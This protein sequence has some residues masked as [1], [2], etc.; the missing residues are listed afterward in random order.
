MTA[1]ASVSRLGGAV[2]A[3]TL[4]LLGGARAQPA[5]EGALDLNLRLDVQTRPAARDAPDLD[6]RLGLIEQRLDD[7]RRH[8]RLWQYGWASAN[9]L[10]LVG[11]A[12]DGVA[13]GNHDA[14]VTGIVVAAKSAIGL[15]DL[16]LRPL[17]GL[18][19]A[20]P[21]RA[22][23]GDTPE[24]Q[25][26]RLAAAERLL[27][28]DAERAEERWGWQQHVGNL[29]VNVAGGVATWAFANTTDA[30]ADTLIGLAVGEVQILS[31]PWRPARTLADYDSRF[32]GLLTSMEVRPGPGGVEVAFRF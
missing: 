1:V 21:I 10:G 12:A 32:G 18:H 9:T 11:G 19:G 17:P 29:A 2:V 31:A 25:Q 13:A 20:D 28:A 6:A 14:R 24:Q 8:S 23:P 30:V 5:V 15:A 27:K 4:A 16:Y 7:Q 3:A 26:E 22:M